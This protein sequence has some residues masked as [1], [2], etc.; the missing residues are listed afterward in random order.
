MSLV[1]WKKEFYPVPASRIKTDVMALKHAIR[2]FTGAKPKNLKKH[3]VSLST[4]TIYVCKPTV[5]SFSFDNSTCALCCVHSTKDQDYY[6]RCQA[7]PLHIY[8]RSCTNGGR[9]WPF[10]IFINLDNPNPM[11]KALK[12]V[13]RNV[14]EAKKHELSKGA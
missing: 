7:C 4:G 6:V 3:G 11:L 10:A 9:V 8:T 14:Q 12:R 13:L 2:K 5:R 1:A